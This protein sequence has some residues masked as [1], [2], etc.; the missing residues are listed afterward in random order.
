MRVPQV[1]Y[2]SYTGVLEPLGQSQVLQ[3]VIGLAREHSMTL[4]TF[5]R[6]GA[7]KDTVAVQ[8]I[9]KQCRDAGVKWQRGFITAA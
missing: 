6:P 7:L 5:E 3:Y 4:L 8:A 2:I 1:L 9:E